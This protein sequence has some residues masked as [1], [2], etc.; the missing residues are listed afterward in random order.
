MVTVAR[1]MME[2]GMENAKSETTNRILA[3]KITE[4]I[5]TDGQDVKVDRVAL[6]YKTGDF[7]LGWGKEVVLGMVEDIL[8]GK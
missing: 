7:T 8:N 6:D 4:A 3:E 5:F 1:Q 2:S